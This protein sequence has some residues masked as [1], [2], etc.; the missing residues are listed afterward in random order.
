[1]FRTADQL[2]MITS[3]GPLLWLVKLNVSPNGAPTAG[4]EA[5]GVTDTPV[6]LRSAVFAG[7]PVAVAVGVTVPVAV[8]VGVTVPVAVAVGVTVPVAVAV[9]VTVPVAVAVGVTVPVAVAVGVTVPVAVTVGVAV[10]VTVGVAVSVAVAVGVVVAV[11]VA[12]AVRVGVTVA[13]AVAVGVTVAVAVAV[14][15]TVA[16][17]VAVGVTVAVAVAVAVTVAVTVGEGDGVTPPGHSVLIPSWALFVVSGKYAAPLA[18]R[19]TLFTGASGCSP[20]GVV[21]DDSMVR[22]WSVPSP[23]SG[24]A[25]PVSSTEPEKV[26]SMSGGTSPALNIP[27]PAVRASMLIGC[28]SITC[29]VIVIPAG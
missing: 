8:A 17:A 22:R 14:G 13:V 6:I 4:L 23:D 21:A 15:V 2:A 5:G 16:V 25:E 1:L 26:P 20:V 19:W 3:R 11:A 29:A 28:W 9:G 10:A 24:A 7:L 18:S 12:V 27:L